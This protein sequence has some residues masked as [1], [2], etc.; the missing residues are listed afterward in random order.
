MQRIRMGRTRSSRKRARTTARTSGRGRTEEARATPESGEPA[1][2]R[3]VDCRR[4]RRAVAVVGVAVVTGMA[5]CSFESD[6]PPEQLVDGTRSK[7][8]PVRLDAP[9]RQILTEV[10]S[11]EAKKALAGTAAGEC[12]RAAREHE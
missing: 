1:G 7:A 4:A 8:P 9:N 6:G 10:V 5:G 11:I 12:L 2:V 3:E